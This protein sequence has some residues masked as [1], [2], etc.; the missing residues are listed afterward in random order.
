MARARRKFT[1][2]AD[3]VIPARTIWHLIENSGGTD[4]TLKE[5]SK[6]YLN[7]F[8]EDGTVTEQIDV[9]ESEQV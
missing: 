7:T 2:T 4:M 3:I 9:I 6:L 1:N 5:G 8:L